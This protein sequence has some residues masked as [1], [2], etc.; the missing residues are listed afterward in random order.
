MEQMKVVSTQEEEETGEF[1]C[2]LL[3]PVKDST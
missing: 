1:N 3:P 2:R